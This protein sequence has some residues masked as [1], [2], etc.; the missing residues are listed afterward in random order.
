MENNQPN[1]RST[2]AD[3]AKA[4][5]VSIAT[6]S[7]VINQTGKIREE[8]AQ[9]ILKTARE[10][11][12][13][14]NETEKSVAI[15]PT[16]NAIGFLVPNLLNPFF[17]EL[18]QNISNILVQKGYILTL[19]V[20][21]NDPDRIAN[22]IN[23]LI[24][25]RAC[26]MI[27]GCIRCEKCQKHFDRGLRHMNIVSIQADIENVDRIDTTDEQ[28]TYEI[29]T[30]LIENGHRK[31]GFIGYDYD[32]SILENRLNGYRHALSDHGITVNPDYICS[33][34]QSY[35]SLYQTT[36]SLLSTKDRPTAIHCFNEFTTY[37]AY[38]AIRDMG[39]SIAKDISVTGFDN[40]YISKVLEPQLTTIDTQNEMMAKLAMNMLFDRIENNY[41]GDPKHIYINHYLITRNSVKKIN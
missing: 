37:A 30:H 16:T 6:V 19:C 1:K 36:V 34:E 8:T 14:Q 35:E 2:L 25:Q 40:D 10:L 38:S 26:G 15:P 13:I 24:N 28:G 3:I 17:A 22:S 29:V 7:R 11:N 5:G 9:R 12:Y 18:T 32:I 27:V 21:G 33:C 20:V 41:N 39:L 4:C 23:M 31:I